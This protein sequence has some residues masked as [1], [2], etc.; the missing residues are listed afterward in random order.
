MYRFGNMNKV[1]SYKI[2][3]LRSPIVNG[4][5]YRWPKIDIFSYQENSTHIY[6]YP[7]HQHNPGTMSYITKDNVEPIYLRLLGPLLVPSPYHPRKSLKAM[8]RLGR[9]NAFY[10]CEGNT[11]LHRYNQKAIE[12]WRLPCEE[13]HKSYPFV[14][15]QHNSTTGLCYEELISSQQN[16]SLSL[17]VYKCDEDLQRTL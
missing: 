8:M 14:K 3:S 11:F 13:L 17:Y 4:T 2:F 16:Q 9:S 7:K 15:S 1:T 5:N 12:P 10:V 6:A